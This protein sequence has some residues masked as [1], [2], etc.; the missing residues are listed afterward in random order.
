MIKQVEMKRK[1]DMMQ[2]A[3]AIIIQPINSD[4]S[5][6]TPPKKSGKCPTIKT[7]SA[8]L[9]Q[10][11]NNKRKVVSFSQANFVAS[12]VPERFAN[13][14]SSFY[15]EAKTIN[16]FWKVVKQN[17]LVVDEIE[18]TRA[19]TEKQELTIAVRAF[20]E[21]VMKVK[22]GKKIGNV[23]GYFNGVVNNVM[24]KLYFDREFMEN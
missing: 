2:T 24:D 19:F 18:G 1:K 7:T 9:K 15:H 17:N 13:L 21:F 3:N 6:K 11:I 20:K 12:W 16:E 22:A 10:K 14:A 23:Y 5:D 8:S 4:M